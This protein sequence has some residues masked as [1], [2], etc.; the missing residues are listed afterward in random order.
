MP[1][2]KRKQAKHLG[3]YLS[4]A[5]RAKVTWAPW[6]QRDEREQNRTTVS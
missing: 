1:K 5:V 4:G 2:E 6:L 3:M